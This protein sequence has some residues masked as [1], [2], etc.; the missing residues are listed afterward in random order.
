M[1]NTTLQRANNY[2]KHEPNETLRKYRI[3]ANRNSLSF[4]VGFS[5]VDPEILTVTPEHSKDFPHT[6]T[7]G[8]SSMPVISGLM[9][10]LSYGM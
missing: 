5:A 2:V 9:L 7:Q 3:L 4:F 8:E 1:P 6:R 10:M